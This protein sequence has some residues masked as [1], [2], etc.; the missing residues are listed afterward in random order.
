M[1]GVGVKTVHYGTT[2]MPCVVK[3]VLGC[4]PKK[5]FLISHPSSIATERKLSYLKTSQFLESI[6]NMENG[7]YPSV[8]TVLG[9]TTSQHLLY[10]WQLKMIKQL[11]SLG[12]FKKYVR[13]RMQAGTQYHSCIQRILEEL[14]MRGSFPDDVAEQVTSEVDDC[15]ANYLSSVLPVL[16]MLGNKNMELERPTSHHGL[17]YSG[18]FDATVTYKDALFLIDWKTV[19]SN[20]SKD[21]REIEKMYNDP[22]QLA[23]YVGAVNSDPNFRMLPEIRYGAIVVAKENGSV[24]DVVEMNSS[25]LEVYWNK[26]LDC[27]WQFWTKME[28]FSTVN[29]ACIEIH[30]T[31]RVSNLLLRSINYVLENLGLYKLSDAFSLIDRNCESTVQVRIS[32]QCKLQH[33]RYLTDNLKSIS[34]S[35]L[36]GLNEVSASWLLGLNEISASWLLGL[37]EVSASWLLGLNE[38][39]ASWLLGLNEVSASW[40]LGLNEISASWL[41]GLNEIIEKKVAPNANVKMSM[42]KGQSELLGKIIQIKSYGINFFMQQPCYTISLSKQ[43]IERGEQPEFHL[44]WHSTILAK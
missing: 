41:L 36:L 21:T 8:S 6:T 10:Q 30:G 3:D 38:I 4:L 27:I 2:I 43:L 5:E 23:A 33:D 16:R 11:G 17:C 35:W 37:N 26:W 29:N 22:V 39:S 19:S 12:A 32:Q 40:L 18:R 25:H 1:T 24:A 34:A 14:R 9:C 20:S 28:T 7:R 31:I 15:V 13:V 44:F 42:I